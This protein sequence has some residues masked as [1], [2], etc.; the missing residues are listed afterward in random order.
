MHFERTLGSPSD[1]LAAPWL[2]TTDLYTYLSGDSTV[3]Y[4]HAIE[5]LPVPARIGGYALN[6]E[7]LAAYDDS[8]W[9]IDINE[10]RWNANPLS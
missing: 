9:G 1:T 5:Y 8:A 10:I 2:P 6:H 7:F 3:S 4:W